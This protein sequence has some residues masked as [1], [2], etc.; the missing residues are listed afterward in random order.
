MFG[1]HWREQIACPTFQKTILLGDFTSHFLV[2]FPGAAFY[3]LV[4]RR[5]RQ[6]LKNGPRKGATLAPCWDLFPNLVPLGATGAQNDAP[7]P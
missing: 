6:R 7:G 5:G 4:G 1:L 3:A 2:F